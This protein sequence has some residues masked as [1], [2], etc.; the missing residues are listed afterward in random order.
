MLQKLNERIQG[1]VAW[2]VITLI[3]ITFAL[4]GVDYYLQSRNATTAA[5]E[6]NGH[7]ISK[8]EY[9]LSYRRIRQ[10]RDPSQLTAAGENQLKNQIL[11]GLIINQ[12]SLQAAR[13][14]GFEVTSVQANAAILN[15]P[16]F[17]EDGH[18]SANRFQQAISGALFTPESFQQE[19]RQGMLLNQQRFALIGTAFALPSE[20]ERFVKLYM[21]TR[22]YQY[23]TIPVSQFIDIKNVTEDEVKTYYQAHQSEFLS[24][25]QVGIA[26]IELSMNDTRNLVTVSEEQVRQY[27]DANQNNFLTP[28][29]WR[30]SHLLIAVPESASAEQRALLKQKAMQAY[31]DVKVNPA[32]FSEKV[33]ALS[34]DKVSLAKQG[35]MPWITAGQSALDK[36][37]LK[38]TKPG[39][40]SEPIETQYGYEI[41]KLNE[42]K[43]AI[44]K[45][46]DQ[47]NQEIKEQLVAEKVQAEYAQR[48]EQL[49]DLAYQ[50]PDSLKPA[51]EALGLTIK[52]TKPFPKTGGDSAL[53][54]NK[55]VINTAFSHD[56]LLQGNNSEPVQVDNEKVVVLR[57][58]RHIPTQ[59]KPFA[60]VQD[61]IIARLANTKA[62][63]KA[64]ELGKKILDSLKEN[65]DVKD[66]FTV[67]HLK[68]VPIES[69]MRDSDLAPQI[70]NELAFSIAKPD[71]Y[72]GQSINDTG[73]AIVK[74]NAV[75]DGQ[76]S[77]LDPEQEASITQQLEASY[78]VL[79]YDLYISGMLKKAEIV[80][81]VK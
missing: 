73:F 76:M 45:P 39:Q 40:I 77:Q 13:K 8:Q 72:A 43:P 67:H 30:V 42:Y 47:V 51:A 38:L 66:L 57:V 32:L 64:N 48:L 44:V 23:L 69:A 54:Q 65:A 33:K 26:Y 29:Q 80:H 78:G 16:Q 50:S 28:A 17:Q 41:L 58:N 4:F 22:D 25:E 18:F 24:P 7:T 68:W 75:H 55:Q 61:R 52:Y 34:D 5:V 63:A 35:E 12:L 49:T 74:L 71:Q 62:Q 1:I 36:D 11:D 27:Y 6:V 53:T 46:F 15:I 3:A 79:D 31:Q 81:H 20:V 59:E 2:V 60:E 21:Q 70:V 19:V 37:L 56:V 14:Y 10:M 9:E